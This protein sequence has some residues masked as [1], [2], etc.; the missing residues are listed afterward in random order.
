MSIG[1]AIVLYAS[2]VLALAGLRLNQGARADD[3]LF[4]GLFWPLEVTRRWI[5]VMVRVLIHTECELH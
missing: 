1:L 4:T 2:L 3:A 5:D